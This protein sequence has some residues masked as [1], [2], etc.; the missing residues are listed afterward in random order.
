MQ[1]NLDNSTTGTCEPMIEELMLLVLTCSKSKLPK[2]PIMKC[3][4]CYISK[5]LILFGW[6]MVVGY[7]S[8]TH[9]MCI[10]FIFKLQK[11]DTCW[12]YFCSSK[13][14]S[15]FNENKVFSFNVLLICRNY[16]QVRFFPKKNCSNAAPSNF[17]LT[18]RHCCVVNQ[19]INFTFLKAWCNN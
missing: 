2:G 15:Y 7:A 13:L 6:K 19:K 10:V 16:T 12:S 14:H 11:H 4:I 17:E 5:R 3:Q 1:T 9:K 18:I 8:F